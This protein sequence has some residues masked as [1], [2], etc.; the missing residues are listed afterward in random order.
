MDFTPSSETTR[1]RAIRSFSG[2]L[3]AAI[4]LLFLCHS[5]MSAPG[6]LLKIAV[7]PWTGSALD[8]QLAKILL[9]EKLG[10]RVELVA[11]DENA[12]FPSLANGDLSATMEVW[13]SGH[14]EDH[15]LFIEPIVA[16]TMPV[17]IV[18]A[19]NECSI[20]IK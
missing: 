1:L 20:P 8:A 11:I 7:N 9:E 5:V 15:R 4:F 19:A 3:W 10:Y 2:M 6:P 16:K 18:D 12:Q 14:A 17:K 13:P